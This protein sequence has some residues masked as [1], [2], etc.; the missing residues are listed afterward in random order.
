[1]GPPRVVREALQ[2]AFGR[3]HGVG[4]LGAE[5]TRSFIG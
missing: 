4:H 1:V 3:A 5:H 2:R